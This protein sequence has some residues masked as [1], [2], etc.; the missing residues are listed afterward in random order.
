MTDLQRI[1]GK[2]VRGLT[3]GNGCADL[4]SHGMQD[5]A[6]FAIGIVQ[7]GDVGAAIRIVFDGLDLGRHAFLVATEI[8][9][10]V[11]PLVTAAA[12][13]HHDFAVVVAAASSAFSARVDCFSGV[14]LVISLLSSTVMKRLDAVYGLKLFSPISCLY[15]LNLSAH[16]AALAS[17]KKLQ[18]TNSLNTRSSSRLRRALR[19]LFSN[20]DGSL[21]SGPG[22]ASCRRNWRCERQK[23]SL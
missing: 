13:P 22:D 18:S 14:C 16:L 5:V 17:P 21:R 20:R 2:N 23:P 1:A 11:L 12:V 4:Q 15:L 10:A 7:Q 6:L 9:G 19:R 8:D 3:G